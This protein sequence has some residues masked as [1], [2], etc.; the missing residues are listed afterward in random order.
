[1]TPQILVLCFGGL[2]IL[3]GL[4]GGG[5]TIKGLAVPKVASVARTFS[6]VVG[7]LLILVGVA[8][9]DPAPAESESE[10]LESEELESVEPESE[11][12]PA[13][14][15]SVPVAPVQEADKN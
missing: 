14:R 13:A 8:M 3:I 15:A 4:V 10:E 5:F 2:A 1:M 12:E 7:L 11:P 6:V 9:E